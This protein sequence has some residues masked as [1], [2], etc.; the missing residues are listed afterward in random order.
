MTFSIIIPIYNA[1]NTLRRCLDSVLNQTYPSYEVLLIDDGSSDN[2]AEI[3][4]SYTKE[5]PRFTLV[6]QS[7]TG[8]SRA[9]NRGLELAKGDVVSFVDSDD[10][11][12]PDYLQRLYDA[13]REGGTRVVY[14]GV[15]QI[16]QDSGRRCIRNIP[17]LP[18]NHI[19]QIVALTKEDLFGY[20]WI[21]AF[22]R[23]LV[24]QT[25]FDE[26]LN[27]FEDEVFACQIMQKQPAVS[28][29]DK[30]LYNQIVLPGSLSRKTHQDYYE[31]CEAVYLAW[32]QLLLTAQA[33]D[34]PIL[35]EKANHMTNVCKYYFLER[36][37]S[38]IPF[39][40]G[41]ANCTFFQD[42][43]IDDALIAEIKIGKTGS[44]LIKRTIY[45][46]KVLLRKLTGR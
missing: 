27:L 16:A 46:T 32:R 15:N 9:R 37:V 3:A 39:V 7:N 29:I 18:Q 41:L 44:A 19:D 38:P 42:S 17:D 1:Q 25:R 33:A 26:S 10:F 34:H 13:F 6:Q 4:A 12:E 8:P 28:R 31:K 5:D 35:Q 20:T 45:R 30:P 14:F 22:S 2:S 24:G 11:I 40:R 23:Q 43:T 36:E 21:K